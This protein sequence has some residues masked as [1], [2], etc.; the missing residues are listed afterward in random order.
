VCS[1]L[2][3]IPYEVAGVP[4]FGFGVLLAIWAIAG[5]V[6]IAGLVRRHG[7]DAET[8]SAVPML[9]LLGA[10]IVLLPRI[11]PD[12]LPIRGYGV[13]LLAGIISGVGLAMHRA[14]K[15]GLGPEIILSAAIWIVVC[16]VI[17]ARLFYVVE[18]W[19]ET[20]AGLSPRDTL[21]EIVNIPQGG[22]VIYGGFLG[23]AVGFIA[24][25]RKQGLPLLAMADLATPSLLVGLALGRIGCLLNG[26]CYGGQTDWP[27]HV[28]FPADS[29][30]YADQASRGEL[31]GFKLESRDHAP[32]VVAR[33]EAG[34]PA[35][36][37]GL[38]AGDIVQ[39]INGEPI[40]SLAEARDIVSKSFVGQR[41]LPIELAD[42]K[43][44][45][46]PPVAPPPRS[47]PV[48][49][50]QIYS[51]IDA[52]LLAWLLWAYF[53]F[54]SRDGECVALMLTIHPITRFLLE[55]IR[56]DEPAVF[57]TG[58]S[59]S[60]NISIALLA[61]AAAL[62]WYL[63]RQPRLVTWPLTRQPPALPGVS[64][65]TATKKSVPS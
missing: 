39:A 47:R 51:A 29:P 1:E 27:W 28:T 60:Q 54:R 23:A 50:T 55:V 26:C 43:P 61:C 33:V 7:W 65:R 25:V 64:S 38:K 62:W 32:V 22:L 20:F 6:S 57:G 36:I 49:P 42:S 52:G 30:P 48:H 9:L 58:L 59:I 10:A 44:V 35:D 15:G 4:I 11:F 17:G 41:S 24:F 31:H 37:A 53:P 19:N 12:G 21:L 46:I 5:A 18:Y 40:D 3:R 8:W 63:S 45:S 16:G 34:S 56:T 14:Q 2:F 13:M